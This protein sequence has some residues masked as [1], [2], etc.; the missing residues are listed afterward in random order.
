MSR[1]QVLAQRLRACRLIL[2]G[3]DVAY[4]VAFRNIT[5]HSG[6]N[7]NINLFLVDCPL[8]TTTFIDG[9]PAL[10]LRDR[11]GNIR[12]LARRKPSS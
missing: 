7:E 2:R 11:H 8:D 6:G 3:H 9:V 4:H 5:I 1:A 12:V 10:E